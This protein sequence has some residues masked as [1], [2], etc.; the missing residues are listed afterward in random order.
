MTYQRAG[1]YVL[2]WSEELDAQSAKMFGTSSTLVKRGPKEQPETADADEHPAKRVKTE[3]GTSDLDDEIKR[4]FE[5]GTVAKVR[6]NLFS[7]FLISR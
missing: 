5:K 6:A 4:N 1:D 3:G 2:T 7:I